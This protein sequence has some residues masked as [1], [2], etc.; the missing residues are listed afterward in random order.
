MPWSADHDHLAWPTKSPRLQGR[1]EHARVLRPKRAD[2]YLP[3]P[4]KR[5]KGDVNWARLA[6]SPSLRHGPRPTSDDVVHLLRDA[7]QDPVQEIPAVPAGLACQSRMDGR[8]L[9]HR[10]S[11]RNCCVLEG[12]LAILPAAAAPQPCCALSA[13]ARGLLPMGLAPG[14]AFAVGQVV[15]Q[16]VR[17]SLEVL[18]R[19]PRAGL[20]DR[21]RRLPQAPKPHRKT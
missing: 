17:A 7:I 19:Q 18:L 21:L 16:L 8:D 12:T 2:A 11:P 14:R 4:A 9:I 10:G 5:A 1:G 20:P 3:K 13:L 15:H 6:V